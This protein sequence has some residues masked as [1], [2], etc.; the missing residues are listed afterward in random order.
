MLRVTDTQLLSRR[1]ADEGRQLIEGWSL[2]PLERVVAE[3]LCKNALLE[4]LCKI[5]MQG[6]NG[7]KRSKQQRL[8]CS[9]VTE[10]AAVHKVHAFM[11]LIRVFANGYSFVECR[12][13]P[14]GGIRISKKVA[15]TVDRAIRVVCGILLT[16]TRKHDG[17]SALKR[18]KKQL[19]A[20]Y[21]GQDSVVVRMRDEGL[22][23]AAAANI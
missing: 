6:R 4:R 13:A 2:S 7:G 5:F 23:M 1:F 19:V 15:H 10:A 17:T 3:Y 18:L 12:S 21:T 14:K 20:A 8:I 11:L 9:A 16:V 22:K